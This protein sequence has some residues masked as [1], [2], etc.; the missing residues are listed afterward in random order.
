MSGKAIAQMSSDVNVGIDEVVSVFVTQY[1]DNLF[2]KKKE[3]SGKIKDLKK[4]QKDLT[5]RLET[6]IDTNSFNTTIAILGLKSK[7]DGVD[8]EWGESEYS[9]R[10][11]TPSIKVNVEIKDTD[12]SEDRYH[13]S[14]TKT[15]SFDISRVD[16][17]QHNNNKTE[18]ESLGAELTEVMGLI[19]SVSRKERQVRGR[20]SKKKLESAGYEDLLNDSEMLKLVSLD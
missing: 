20:I 10:R 4:D 9:K 12:K 8:V 5:K 3:L 19:K 13:S 18:I 6:S 16:V 1:E 15:F 17:D 2:D 11:S 7:V 14:M